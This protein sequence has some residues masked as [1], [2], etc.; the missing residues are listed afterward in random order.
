MHAE[1]V[2]DLDTAEQECTRAASA[3]AELDDVRGEARSLLHLG[4]VRWARGRLP[5]AAAAQDR[6]IALCRSQ[7]H[8]A[9]AG[10]G[11]VLRARTALDAGD[12]ARA[13]EI[14]LE[15]G[16]VVARS[17]DRHLIGLRLE[18]H[19]RV[20]L[21]V[22]SLVE[23]E[24][25]ARAS[26]GIFEQVGYLEGIGAALQTLGRVHLARG[27]P[28]A[29]QT[30]Y[31]QAT[32]HAL[33]MA[34]RPAVVEGVELLAEAAAVRNEV[35]LAARLLGHAQQLRLDARLERTSTQQRR[36][37]AWRH[38]LAPASGAGV[39][40]AEVDGRHATTDELLAELA[41]ADRDQAHLG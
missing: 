11:L 40:A 20:S 19:A 30:C 3:F 24:S 6:S 29:A 26:L 28:V 25:S 34:H 15:A 10:L 13:R 32:E 1:S 21:D 37:D 27:D 36:L 35:D 22:G 18:Q 4:T 17:G 5:E 12:P 39:E 31:L 23:A 33:R 2:G 38:L 8:D 9:G 41:D 16:H 14:L 7:R